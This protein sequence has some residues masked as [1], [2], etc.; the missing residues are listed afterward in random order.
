MVQ[1]FSIHGRWYPGQ[2][3]TFNRH[4]LSQILSVYGTRVSKGEW[5][6]YAL[7]STHD[8]AMFSIFR[9]TNEKPAYVVAKIMRRGFKK[10][11][12]FAVYMENKT[13]KQGDSLLEVLQVFH[14]KEKDK[15]K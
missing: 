12:K 5:K 7:D 4:E 15:K 14:E 11:A 10:Q 9:H 3:V 1:L 2:K 6:D 8:T 13:L